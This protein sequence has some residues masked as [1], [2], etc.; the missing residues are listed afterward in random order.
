MQDDGGGH[1]KGEVAE[2]EDPRAEAKRLRRQAH[3]LVHGQ[4]GEAYVDAI[5]KGY[6]IEEHQERNETPGDLPNRTLFEEAGSGR[7]GVAH[8]LPLT[9]VPDAASLP[10]LLELYSQMFGSSWRGDGMVKKAGDRK[11]DQVEAEALAHFA[12]LDPKSLRC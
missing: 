10:E 6:E 1:F 7:C 9:C 4:R 12:R 11:S 2:E 8:T 3:I 5:E